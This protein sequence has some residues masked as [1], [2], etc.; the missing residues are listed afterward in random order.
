MS[1]VCPDD[2]G[3][4]HTPLRGYQLLLGVASSR[5]S[6]WSLVH[7]VRPHGDW[8]LELDK[9]LA[10]SPNN[11]ATTGEHSLHQE[12]LG[13]GLSMMIHGSSSSRSRRN[14][15][16]SADQSMEAISGR[17]TQVATLNTNKTATSLIVQV[18]HWSPSPRHSAVTQA[19]KNSHTFRNETRPFTDQQHAL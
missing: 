10:A 1:K 15:G 7:L 19:S 2:Q 9:S 5:V 12:R 18:L 16:T 14:V 6:C 4:Q 3:I 13:A 17:W 11:N 8:A